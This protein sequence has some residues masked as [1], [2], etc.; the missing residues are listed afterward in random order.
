YVRFRAL[1]TWCLEHRGV[2]IAA[3]AALFLTSV[4]A[5]RFVQQQFFPAASRPELIVDLRLPEGASLDATQA[6]V[7]K[8]EKILSTDPAIRDRLENF[9]SYVGSGSPRFYLPFDQQLVNANF[10]QF[11]LNT[12][13]NE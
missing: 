1:V 11:I 10:G 2:V 9:V 5:F 4:V 13:S 7:A 12:K 3:T 6:Q 8:L